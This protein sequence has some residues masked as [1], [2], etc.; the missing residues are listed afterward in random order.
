VHGE[1]R[2]GRRQSNSGPTAPGHGH[3]VL[4]ELVSRTGR[5]G[6][7]ALSGPAARKA[8]RAIIADPQNPNQP[9]SSGNGVETVIRE[10]LNGVGSAER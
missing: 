4:E 7:H 1:S 2:S 5:G 9:K 3:P 8:L 6:G 10:I